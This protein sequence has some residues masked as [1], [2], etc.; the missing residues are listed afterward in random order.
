MAERSRI[1][2]GDPWTAAW[3]LGT[4]T[5]LTAAVTYGAKQAQEQEVMLH[6][7]DSLERL[8]ESHLNRPYHED[9]GQRLLL[10]ED[11]AKALNEKLLHLESDFGA[12]ES[13]IERWGGAPST[14]RSYGPSRSQ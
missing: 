14:W 10:L 13:R 2:G 1:L 9:A 6:R 5:L 4:I 7:L 3:R 8:L 11:K 12:L